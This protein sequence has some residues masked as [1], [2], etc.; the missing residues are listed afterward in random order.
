MS[1]RRNVAWWSGIIA[2][3][4]V[5]LFLFF[6]DLAAVYIKRQAEAFGFK[7]VNVVLGYPGVHQ[8]VIPL[9]SLEKDLESETARVTMRNVTLAYQFPHVLAGWINEMRIEDAS[10]TFT[11][12]RPTHFSLL[13]VTRQLPRSRRFWHKLSHIYRLDGCL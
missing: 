10:L 12:N 6:P 9:V 7:N 13:P 3:F 5:A 1:R 2:S 11:Q 8:I 4:A